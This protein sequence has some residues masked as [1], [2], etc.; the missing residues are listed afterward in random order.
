MAS[1]SVGANYRVVSSLLQSRWS[2]VPHLF[3]LYVIWIIPTI[4]HEDGQT[5][6]RHR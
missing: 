3:R 2:S 4:K 5:Y 6:A 1:K